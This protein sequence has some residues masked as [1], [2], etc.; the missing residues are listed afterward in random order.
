[1]YTDKFLNFW[2]LYL[3][4]F[5]SHCFLEIFASFPNHDYSNPARLRKLLN[6]QRH[7]RIETCVSESHPQLLLTVRL[8]WV[9]PHEL[10]ASDAWYAQ[11][12][13]VPVDIPD[14][15]RVTEALLPPLPVGKPYHD[16]HKKCHSS[17]LTAQA[18]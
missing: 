17:Y 18:R 16:L 6:V 8:P 5:P 4:I 9:A 15:V 11:G 13:D 3:Q 10:V 1:M 7:T 14:G 12:V 2:H